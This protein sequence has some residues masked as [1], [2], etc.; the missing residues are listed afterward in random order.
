MAFSGRSGM[1][2]IDRERVKLQVYK[3]CS[4][5]AMVC[6]AGVDIVLLEF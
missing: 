3:E 6:V 5:G 2:T 1:P 4:R